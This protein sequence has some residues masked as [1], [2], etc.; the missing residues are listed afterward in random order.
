MIEVK[1]Q[2]SLKDLLMFVYENLYDLA[3]KKLEDDNAPLKSEESHNLRGAVNVLLN[4]AYREKNIELGKIAEDFEYILNHL[5][6]ANFKA[7]EALADAKRAI[8][9]LN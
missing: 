9:K 6:L 7:K 5:E 1:E 4:L 3:N 2:I 8:E